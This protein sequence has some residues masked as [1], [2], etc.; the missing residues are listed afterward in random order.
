M[1]SSFNY[2]SGYDYNSMGSSIP[3]NNLYCPPMPMFPPPDDSIDSALLSAL[4]NPRE[5]MLL[6]QIE[7]TIHNFVKSR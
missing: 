7:D 3:S 2:S 4:S 5:R 6:L 1:V